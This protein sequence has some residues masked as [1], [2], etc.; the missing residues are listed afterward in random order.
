M[1]KVFAWRCIAPGPHAGHVLGQQHC[2]SSSQS[3]HA[4]AWL[5]HGACKFYRRERS[6]S[7]FLRQLP[8]RLV[9]VLLVNVCINSK[10]VCTHTVVR[11]SLS[12]YMKKVKCTD[13]NT[14]LYV[15]KKC[16]HVLECRWFASREHVALP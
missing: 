10:R 12:I 1:R 7:I 6:Y 15:L 3:T 9:R 5:A 13:M 4:R 8:P 16:V 2:N 11:L 14:C